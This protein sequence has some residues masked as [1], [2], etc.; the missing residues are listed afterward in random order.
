M[1]VSVFSQYCPVWRQNAFEH[2]AH[3]YQPTDLKYPA[4]IDGHLATTWCHAK[5]M[6]QQPAVSHV[7]GETTAETGFILVF[8]SA[9]RLI[10]PGCLPLDGLCVAPALR[11]I[12]L[13]KGSDK[14]DTTFKG[15]R[16]GVDERGADGNL[17]L[18]MPNGLYASMRDIL[19]A[20]C[21][22]LVI[23]WP[24]EWVR[25]SDGAMQ[26]RCKR[27][28]TVCWRTGAYHWWLCGNMVLSC[29]WSL[30]WK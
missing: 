20:R 2:S 4:Y 29:V 16:R 22:Y 19:V 14:D 24:Q 1:C 26:R 15:A 9:R 18:K 28:G 27:M 3:S 5:A 6:T 25:V 7:S 17:V 11:I 8:S 21:Q 13:G 10:W 12:A 23:L 30:T